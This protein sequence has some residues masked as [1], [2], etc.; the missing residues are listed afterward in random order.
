MIVTLLR[1]IGEAS[2]SG[3]LGGC[4]NLVAGGA[5]LSAG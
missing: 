3:G 4:P 1:G 5:A 2:G